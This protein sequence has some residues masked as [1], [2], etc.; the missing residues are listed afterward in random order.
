MGPTQATIISSVRHPARA[1]VWV[2]GPLDQ[3]GIATIRAELAAW[4]EA[5]VVALCLDVSQMPRCDPHLAPSLARALAWART[6]LRGC[7]GDLTLTGARA[8]L[9]AEWMAAVAAPD[10]PRP[11]AVTPGA[12]TPGAVTPGAVT[13]GAVTHD[14][15]R[16]SSSLPPRIPDQLGRTRH[17]TSP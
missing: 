4:R 9:H 8:H 14:P 6:Q 16:T 12:V 17:R 3:T 11:G 10:P 15:P 1:T 2:S 5:G 13:P 7:G